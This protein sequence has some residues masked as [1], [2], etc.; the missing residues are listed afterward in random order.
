MLTVPLMSLE[1]KMCKPLC[2]KALS[3]IMLAI[4]SSQLY[5]VTSWEKS[6]SAWSAL[7]EHFERNTLANKLF[8]NK[9][10]SFGNGEGHDCRSAFKINEGTDGSVSSTGCSSECGR[11]SCVAGT[12]PTTTKTLYNKTIHKENKKYTTIDERNPASE[13]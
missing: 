7:T 9:V 1:R 6:R 2:K 3:V 5:L 13:D 10:F 8:L 4:K 11:P 12:L